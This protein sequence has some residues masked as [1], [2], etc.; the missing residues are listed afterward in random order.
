MQPLV[1]V[2]MSAYNVDCF[3]RECLDCVVNQTL[4]NIEIICVN[5]GSTDG[6]LAILEEYAAQD[7]RIKII[8]K[9]ENEGL[10]VARN[11][12]LALA[13]GKYVGFV[14]GDDLLDL[15]LFRKAYDCA[16]KNNSELVLWDYAVFGKESELGGNLLKASTFLATSP[17]DKV[18]LLNRPAFAWT[19]LIRTI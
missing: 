2:T 8:D 1:S 7:S 11:E 19:K 17:K 13:T 10:S 4:H 16:E 9:D 5:D 3:L 6:T 15:D 14:D 12:A 18:A